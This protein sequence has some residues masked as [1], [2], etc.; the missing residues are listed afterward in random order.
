MLHG[1]LAGRT[2]GYEVGGFA[3]DGDNAQ[4]NGGGRVFGGRTVAGRVA[5]N[6]SATEGVVV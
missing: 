5:L 4:P 1:R 3:H 6:R 2:L